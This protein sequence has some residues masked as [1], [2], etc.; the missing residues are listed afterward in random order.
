MSKETDKFIKN[1]K[2]YQ[3]RIK[4][5]TAA[6]GEK[7]KKD[8]LSHLKSTWDD[9][10]KLIAEIEKAVKSGITGSKPSDFKTV[11]PIRAALADWKTAIEKHHANVDA[12]VE[13]SDRGKVLE[14][15]IQKNVTAI[16]KD[17]KKTKAKPD[18]ETAAILK[19]CNTALKD[20]KKVVKLG[21]TLPG[22]VVFYA[23]KLQRSVEV[24]F[25]KA[26]KSASPK[27]FPKSMQ[28][29]E[30]KRTL[31]KVAVFERKIP[32]LCKTA[33]G[34]VP[35]DMK[36]AEKALKAAKSELSDLQKLSDE[37]ASTAKKM[38][39]EISESKDKTDLI[40]LIKSVTTAFKK[41]D[42]IFDKADE[43]IEQAQAQA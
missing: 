21:G 1:F 29:S 18:K 14:G 17:L 5:H 6:E 2:T 42:D 4:A 43:M 15:E 24:T 23:R 27:E 34:Y 41:C 32:T 10:D 7:R 30:R 8:V 26:V 36:N 25:T 28:E 20:L 16:D 40:A 19:E 13:F 11:M 38:K 35:D 9:E 37:C 22:H 12:L 3:T 39:K 31:R 33:M